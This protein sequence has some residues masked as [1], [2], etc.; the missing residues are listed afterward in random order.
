MAGE[1]VEGRVS[2][3][4]QLRGL[5]AHRPGADHEVVLAQPLR[6][7]DC[8]LTRVLTIAIDD[9]H[10]LTRGRADAAL[11]C[12]AVPFVVRV[13]HDR[14]SGRLRARTRAVSGPVVYDD[15]LVPR[16]RGRE[17]SDDFC[18][19]CRF[20]IGR[21][22]DRDA[23]GFGQD[24]QR[25]QRRSGPAAARA[26]AAAG[27]GVGASM[28]SGRLCRSRERTRYTRSSSSFLFAEMTS[29]SRPMRI[30]WKPTIIRTA[31]RIKD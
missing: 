15:D 28:L 20:V 19:D 21:D 10:V 11:D 24:R 25:S 7:P 6:E 12:R 8:V 5:R 29:A 23:G 3:S 1:T 17:G 30:T 4:P 16:T 26:A 13:P 14:G 2:E 31:D 27:G 18:D 22:D 9:Q